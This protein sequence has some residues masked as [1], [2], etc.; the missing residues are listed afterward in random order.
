MFASSGFGALLKEGSKHFSGLEE[1]ILRNIDACKTLSKM[2]RS[3]L[4]PHGMNKMVINH[5]D[6]LFVTSDAATIIREVEVN[7]PAARMIAMA[8]KMQESEAGDG[9]NFVIS[10]AG[11]LMQ[12]AEQLLKMGLH[13]SEILI[14]YEKGAK[15]AL[16][17]VEG[18]SCYSIDSVKNREDLQKCIRAPISSKQFGLEDFLSGLI[19]QASLYAMPENPTKFNVDQVRVQK[20]LGGT[21]NDSQVIHGMV[22]T[23][24]SETSFHHVEK[25]KIAIFNTSIEM[26]QGETKGTVLLKNA[27]DL[28]N[29]TK[30]EE[31]QFEHFI[32]GLAEAG[33]TVVIGSGSISE[34][35]IHFF[36]KYKIFVLKLMSK[37]E[38]KRI[39][40][41]VGAVAVVKLG[42]PTPEE[43]GYADEV[44]VKEISS[45]KVTIF[46]RDE[47]E[48]KLATIVLRGSTNSLLDDAERAID[49][50]VN[51]VKS[52]VKDKR[53]LP[54]GGATEIHL[55]S[56]IQTY[57]K[58]Q[59]GLDQY[60]V[61]K[62][63]Q[64]FEVIPRTLADNAGLKAE[65]IIAKLYAETVKGSLFGLDVADGQVKDMKECA[66]FDSMEVK[67]WAIKLAI[68]AV[69][70]ILRVDQI[71]MAKPA[72]GPKP[73]DQ[74]APDLDD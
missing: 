46:R 66:I 45:T 12:Q 33:V 57:A 17:I 54:G 23:R 1:A 52:L 19:A 5:L 73:R 71:I 70:T 63:G 41:S 11:E 38:L 42:T 59:P 24:G 67:T 58:T 65:E 69:L 53:L 49:D 68:D 8:A 72:G 55:A 37:W 9:T 62:F 36:E 44:T 4:G 25:A 60:A 28:L 48:N 21:I 26:Q 7:H 16:E 29:Y 61:E 64:A 18:L 32:K 14:G 34:L 50:G 39:A 47:D 6:K 3:S 56:K 31:D 20:V 51:T 2:T 15:Q 10:F 74:N 35:A 22:V 40:K 30:G 13:P 43:L 27:D